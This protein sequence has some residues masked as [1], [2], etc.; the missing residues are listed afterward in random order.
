MARGGGSEEWQSLLSV[1]VTWV[2]TCWPMTKRGE[3]T[4]SETA[5]AFIA[6][7]VWFDVFGAVCL[8]RRPLLEILLTDILSD[9]SLVQLN[10]FTGCDNQVKMHRECFSTG[11][12]VALLP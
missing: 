12:N 8:R 5:K 3:S 6:L 9:Q 1:A 7:T 10:H 2:R 4:L 11:P